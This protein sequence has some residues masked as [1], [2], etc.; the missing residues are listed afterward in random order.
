MAIFYQK[1]AIVYLSFDTVIL[2][3]VQFTR[4]MVA[5][6]ILLENASSLELWKVPKTRRLAI[7]FSTAK[8]PPMA[9]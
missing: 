1:L 7:Y 8:D 4:R 6:T 9:K 2:Y 5:F 3:R